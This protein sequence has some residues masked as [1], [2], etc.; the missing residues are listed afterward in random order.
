VDD[1]DPTPGPGDAGENPRR[2]S[3]NVADHIPYLEQFARRRSTRFPTHDPDEVLSVVLFE[4]DRLLREKYDPSQSTITTFLAVFL[5]S[6]VTYRLLRGCGMR[7]RSG[8]WVT[9]K[10][11]LRDPRIR[12]TPQPQ[13]HDDVDLEDLLA[14]CHPETRPIFR[15]LLAGKTVEELALAEIASQTFESTGQRAK[16]LRTRIDELRTILAHEWGRLT[17]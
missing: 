4:A 13:P 2:R 16:A 1:S 15:E 9:E 17:R 6:R 8:T 10:D 14:A 12:R 7:Y 11:L 3:R 5:P